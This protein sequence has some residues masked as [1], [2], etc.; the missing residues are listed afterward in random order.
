VD[1]LLFNVRKEDLR[2]LRRVEEEAKKH[3]VK[4]AIENNQDFRTPSDVYYA[5][6]DTDIGFVLNTSNARDYSRNIEGFIKMLRDRI[7]GIHLSDWYQGIGGLPYSLGESAFLDPVLK[8]FK[9]GS[10]VLDLDPRYSVEDVVI[11]IDKLKQRIRK[12]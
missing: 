9:K 2:K 4:I 5:L 7:V 12:L 6:S 1:Y 3:G 11:S 8:E 10:V